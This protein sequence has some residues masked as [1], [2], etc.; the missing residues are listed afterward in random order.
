MDCNPKSSNYSSNP[1]TQLY[2][3]ES[4]VYDNATPEIKEILSDVEQAHYD[5][6]TID[7]LESLT[8][9]LKHNQLQYVRD[10]IIYYEI[11]TKR[12]YKAKYS[13]YNQWAQTEVGMTSWRC[14]QI[15]EASGVTLKLIAAGH[16]KLP[17]NSSGNSIRYIYAS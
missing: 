13:N 4:W 5:Y 6:P 14:K 17:L 15:I 8:Q 2:Q 10:G 3:I 1:F 16:T 7:H 9:Q 11:L 12:L